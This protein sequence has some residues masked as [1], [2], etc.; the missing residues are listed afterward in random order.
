MHGQDN[1]PNRCF[2]ATGL[3]G[4]RRDSGDNRRQHHQAQGHE[5]PGGNCETSH[6]LGRADEWP[7]PTGV[8]ERLECHVVLDLEIRPNELQDADSNHR[9]TEHHLQGTERSVATTHD[10]LS[11][12]S[13]GAE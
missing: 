4:E 9:E 2:F 5:D 8:D 10:N 3:Q 7:Q 11:R 12:E 13:A 6:R 1:E